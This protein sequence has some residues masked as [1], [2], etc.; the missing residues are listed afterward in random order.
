MK[1]IAIGYHVKWLVSISIV[2]SHSIL[3]QQAMHISNPIVKGN[4][5]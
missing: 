1:T 4:G 2:I 3:R 5:G